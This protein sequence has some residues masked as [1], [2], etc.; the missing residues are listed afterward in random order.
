MPG[1]HSST[2][3]LIPAVF[4]TD[5]LNPCT[6]NPWIKSHKRSNGSCF[7]R[8][9]IS[10]AYVR[11]V[12]LRE[13]SCKC[14]P[15]LTE[16]KAERRPVH[17]LHKSI[18]GSKPQQESCKLLIIISRHWS[19]AHHNWTWNPVHWTL[20]ASYTSISDQFILISPST[21]TSFII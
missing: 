17:R 9:P 14:F 21:G 16:E 13:K 3:L 11:T 5:I 6:F 2:P 20:T 19:V 10:P 4:F 15:P 18:I 7:D 1:L 8:K 12:C